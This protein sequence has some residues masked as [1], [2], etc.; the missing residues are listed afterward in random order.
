M[1]GPSRQT[2]RGPRK[3]VVHIGMPKTGTTSI[4]AWLYGNAAEL[5]RQGFFFKRLPLTR[6]RPNE[7]AEVVICQFAEAGILLPNQILRYIYG[8][9]TLDDQ[10]RVAREYTDIFSCAL[11]R[12]SEETVILSVEDVGG[13]TRSADQVQGLET[14]LSRF[15]DEVSYIVYFR[16]QE[17]FLVSAYSQHIKTGG[18]LTLEEHFEK[19]KARNYFRLVRPWIDVVGRDRF[20][21]RLLESDSLYQNDLLADFAHELGIDPSGMRAV[22]RRNEALTRASAEYLRVLNSN[23]RNDGSI[24]PL[25]EPIY[26]GLIPFLGKTFADGERI[27]LT[28]PQIDEVR[29][30]NAAS[31]ERLRSLFFPDRTE[32]F[33]PRAAAPDTTPPLSAEAVAHVGIAVL[34]AKHGDKTGRKSDLRAKKDIRRAPK[35]HHRIWRRLK[36]RHPRLAAR[37]GPIVGRKAET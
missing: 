28:Q 18:T 4:Q 1:T 34:Q 15:F 5:S 21:V 11:S 8:I 22:P 27:R 36:E 19:K 2:G 25:N 31:N 23:L 17:D 6:A 20:T 10:S 16:R 35:L 13:M 30:V 24:Y 32:L 26:G 9:E 33:P 3:A 12:A 37:I 14:W 29:A 7:H